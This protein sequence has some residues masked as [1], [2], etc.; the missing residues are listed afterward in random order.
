M[1]LSDQDRIAMLSAVFGTVTSEDNAPIHE[2]HVAFTEGVT[3]L[4]E[5]LTALGAQI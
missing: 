5:T 3:A 4:G 2:S 1:K